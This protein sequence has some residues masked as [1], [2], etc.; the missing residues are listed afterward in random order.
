MIDFINKMPASAV[1]RLAGNDRKVDCPRVVELQSGLNVNP[2]SPE[3]GMKSC[4]KCQEISDIAGVDIS[5]EYES[6]GQLKC[7]VGLGPIVH[8]TRRE[9]LLESRRDGRSLG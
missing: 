7:P 6:I 2:I 5:M 9:S 4:D 3:M 1:V 8:R